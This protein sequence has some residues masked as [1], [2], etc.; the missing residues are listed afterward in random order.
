MLK[1]SIHQEV[2]IPSFY[3]QKN[4]HKLIPQILF[5]FEKGVGSHSKRK[6]D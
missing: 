4:L 5:N 1:L 2:G 6:E 3:L